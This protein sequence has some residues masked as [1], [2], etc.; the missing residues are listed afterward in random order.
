MTRT[1]YGHTENEIKAY[2]EGLTPLSPEG[3][4]PHCTE[5][6]MDKDG[7]N[8]C[9]YNS[10]YDDGKT[11]VELHTHET[12]E[13]MILALPTE[14]WEKKFDFLSEG[15]FHKF[16]FRVVGKKMVTNGMCEACLE[17]LEELRNQERDR[18]MDMSYWDDHD[19][20]VFVHS[21]PNGHPLNDDEHYCLNCQ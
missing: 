19:Y 14:T 4:C 16:D 5:G 6:L 20:R 17:G 8:D 18:E 21:C 1:Y 12:T 2:K 7:N 15:N 3:W 9:D 10:Y 13:H 11:G